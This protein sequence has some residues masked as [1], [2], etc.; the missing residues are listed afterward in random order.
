MNKIRTE[1]YLGKEQGERVRQLRQITHLSRRAFALKYDLSP[2][3]LQNCEDGRYHSLTKKTAIKLIN[4]F[5]VEGINCQLDWL[6]YGE[7]TEPSHYFKT[8]TSNPSQ[9]ATDAELLQESLKNEQKHQLNKKFFVATTEG[10]HHEVVKLVEDNNVNIYL[11]D[12][13]AIKVYERNHNTPLHL[14][15]L[16]GHFDIV[17]YLLKK[18]ANVNSYNKKN[19]SPLHLA[20]HNAHSNVVEELIAHGAKL[21]ILDNEGD[22][23]LAWATYKG[24]LN[25]AK[26]LISLN[27]NSVN[28]KN[29]FGNTPL[30]WAASEGYIEIVHL[31][32]KSGALISSQNNEGQTPLLIAVTRGQVDTVRYLLEVKNNPSLY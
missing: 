26:K 32:I 5:Q 16:N 6:L 7:G 2:G 20:V 15:A 14:A 9:N 28:M 25:I 4:A 18:N 30:H 8:L 24:Q 17:K 22:T 10:R 12:G 31:L 27:K 11:Q 3:T 23:P 1:K 19:Q 21:D 29:I 13:I